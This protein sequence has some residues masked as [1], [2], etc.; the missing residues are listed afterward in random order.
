MCSVLCNLLPDLRGCASYLLPLAAA[1]WWMW[2]PSSPLHPALPSVDFAL[3]PSRGDFTRGIVTRMK[4]HQCP[5]Q[6]ESSFSMQ[7]LTKGLYSSGP[8]NGMHVCSLAQC[9]TAS[10]MF[11][12]PP[13]WTRYKMTWRSGVGFSPLVKLP[14][15][16][17]APDLR[18]PAGPFFGGHAPGE[19]GDRL[20]AR[21]HPFCSHTPTPR[22]LAMTHSRS[23]TPA[24]NTGA[25][26]ATTPRGSLKRP[27]DSVGGSGS[28]LKSLRHSGPS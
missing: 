3:V 17:P 14:G 1:V 22:S 11:V 21:G 5:T 2:S 23:P 7:D 6:R 9:T 24:R 8:Y 12:N 27:R 16:S 28:E 15:P 10:S 25:H 26:V 19:T 13:M 20:A 18:A 4:C